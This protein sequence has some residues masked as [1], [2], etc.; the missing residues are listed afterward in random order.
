MTKHLFLNIVAITFS[1]PAMANNFNN[2]LLG[3]IP[4]MTQQLV[5]A[6]QKQTGR[7]IG[8]NFIGLRFCASVDQ[9]LQRLE[10]IDGSIHRQINP[11][12]ADLMMIACIPVGGENQCDGPAPACSGDGVCEINYPAES[13]RPFTPTMV[14]TILQRVGSEMVHKTN[15]VIGC[16]KGWQRQERLFVKSS[17]IDV[18]SRSVNQWPS[19]GA[20]LECTGSGQC[21]KI[22]IT[23]ALIEPAD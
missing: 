8:S 9:T 6:S 1:I 14:A 23:Q 15:G 18:K 3:S 10:F 7:D 20:M 19:T 22:S 17:F 12:Q 4:G 16:L 11:N 21:K 2:Y 13:R 5:I